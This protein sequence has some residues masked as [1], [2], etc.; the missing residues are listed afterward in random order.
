MLSTPP[1][2]IVDAIGARIN[3]LPFSLNQEWISKDVWMAVK[4]ATDD[5]LENLTRAGKLAL[6]TCYFDYMTGHNPSS[7]A[8]DLISQNLFTQR[9]YKL[10]LLQAK[11][12]LPPHE[13]PAIYSQFFLFLVASL[14]QSL[15]P[16]D[17]VQW[18]ADV[19]SPLIEGAEA[20]LPSDDI[21][22][23][24]EA[25]RPGK[26]A[27]L[28]TEISR[29]FVHFITLCSDEPRPSD[30]TAKQLPVRASRPCTI[31]PQASSLRIQRTENVA[32]PSNPSA[33]HRRT[34]PVSSHVRQA[35][36]SVGRR[37]PTPSTSTPAPR[38][39]APPASKSSLP[40]S[41]SQT[42]RQTASVSSIAR[43]SSAPSA[44]SFAPRLD[45]MPRSLPGLPPSRSQPI[46][47]S[48]TSVSKDEFSRFP[49]RSTS[50]SVTPLHFCPLVSFYQD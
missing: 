40:S 31:L 19:F 45:P 5:D 34:K 13:P 28:E 47:G 9:T 2:L 39:T 30:R 35:T 41:S 11:S 38:R 18:F 3:K 49:R 27:K 1:Q 8:Y 44:S 26:K 14:Q 33:N 43:R 42:I 12:P 15:K 50:D 36:P 21:Q 48:N 10:L 7:H 20:V 25:G 6:A 23:A 24:V 16:A 29:V 32:G 46:L 22:D 4:T 37:S 17:L